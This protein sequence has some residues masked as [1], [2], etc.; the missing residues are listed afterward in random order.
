MHCGV[1]HGAPELRWDVVSMEPVCND[2][3]N[4]IWRRI[5]AG[6]L[7]SVGALVKGLREGR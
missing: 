6:A 2:R 5:V 3:A 1:G 4:G 7:Q